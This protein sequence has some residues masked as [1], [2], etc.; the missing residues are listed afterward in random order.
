MSRPIHFEIQ[1]DDLDRAKA[2]YAEV[3]G[4][5]YEDY[6]QA[7]GS[8]YWGVMTGPEDSPGINGGMLERSAPSPGA[9]QG[10]NAAVLTMGVEDFDAAAA[11]IEAA[12]GRVTQP[13]TALMGMAWQGYFLDTEGN[14]FGLHQPD[15]NAA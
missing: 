6:S 9:G 3:F 2:F 1:V 7:T 10:A 5:T 15:E 14:T 11:K 4:W 8:P 12:G 13:K